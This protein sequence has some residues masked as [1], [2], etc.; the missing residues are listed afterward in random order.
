MRTDNFAHGEILPLFLIY[1]FKI[2]IYSLC[3]SA[4]DCLPFVYSLGF[5][6]PS[7]FAVGGFFVGIVS[8]FCFLPYTETR[9]YMRFCKFTFRIMSFVFLGCI[10]IV[11]FTVFYKNPDQEFCS[12]C[13][14]LDWSVIIFFCHFF[15]FP[16]LLIFVLF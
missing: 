8:G 15:S 10:M 6:L 12:W 14:Y 3:C 1:L 11:G 5:C 9:K 7:C 13:K 16:F 2:H 4:E